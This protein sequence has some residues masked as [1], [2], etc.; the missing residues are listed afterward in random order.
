MALPPPDNTHAG[1]PAKPHFQERFFNP[2]AG[3]VV[4]RCR[5]RALGHPG[6]RVYHRHSGADVYTETF[7]LTD[8]ESVDSVVVPLGVPTVFGVVV[9][10]TPH[11]STWGGDR[12]RV[13]SAS[14]DTPLPKL[15]THK[16]EGEPWSLVS[17]LLGVSHDGTVLYCVANAQD[18]VTDRPNPIRYAIF[19]WELGAERVSEVAQL[20]GIFW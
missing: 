16:W 15:T 8:A 6:S 20:P 11:G 7:G 17:E 13:V 14:L 5:D 3:V 2:A 9:T 18:P 1:F 10:W 4:V 12:H 19:R